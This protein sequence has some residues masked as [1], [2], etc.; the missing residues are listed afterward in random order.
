MA[1]P[2]RSAVL[3]YLTLPEK[4]TVGPRWLVPTLEAL[5]LVALVLATAGMRWPA[6]RRVSSSLQLAAVAT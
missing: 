1:G 2:A 5:L 3:L 6:A 4:L